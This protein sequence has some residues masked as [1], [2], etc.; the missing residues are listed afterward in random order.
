MT[1]RAIRV[2]IMGDFNPEYRSHH[3][4]NA[5]LRH[6]ADSLGREIEVAWLTTP[7]LLAPDA[8]QVLA[9]YDALWASAGSPYQSM[10]GML[11]GIQFARVRDWPFVGT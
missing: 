8:E 2:G 6:A 10:D 11:A 3:A 1:A 9:G 4:T 7:S 5:S